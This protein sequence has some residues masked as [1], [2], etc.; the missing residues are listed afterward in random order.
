MTSSLAAIAHTVHERYKT[1]YFELDV[2]LANVLG[3]KLDAKSNALRPDNL[4]GIVWRAIIEYCDSD[5][6]Q[7]ALKQVILTDIAEADV[8][9]G[10][11]GDDL[12]ID[13]GQGEVLTVTLQLTDNQRNGLE[14]IEFSDGTTWDRVR[15]RNE[16]V[17]DLSAT[18]EAIG[19]QRD[20]TYVHETGEGSYRITDFDFFVRRVCMCGQE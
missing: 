7:L 9:L 1:K 3:H 15:I 18:G 4:C 14:I 16:M 13:L 11:S 17:E 19:T 5:R 12:L 10:S 20:E 6:V 2:R 8:T